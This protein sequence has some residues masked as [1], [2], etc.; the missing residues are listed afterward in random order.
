MSTRIII[1]DDHEIFR[2]GFKILLK[3]Q[4][5]VE[6]IAEAENGQEL[7]QLVNEHQPDLVI[8]DIQ[9]PIM[10]GVEA[11]RVLKQ[12]HPDLG[13]IALSMFNDEDSVVN[14][15]E[16][17]AKGYLLKNTNKQEL[18]EAVETVYNGNVYYC[19]ATS[20]RLTKLIAESKFNP[21]KESSKTVFSEREIKIMQLMCEQ[22]S[23]KEIA[24]ALFLSVRTI[25]GY[26]EKIHEKTNSKNMIG[27]AIYAIKHDYYKIK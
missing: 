6:L 21:Y 9:M 13:I 19:K 15:L 10:N 14:M 3:N 24:D 12:Q 11:T 22:L 7:V 16:A 17:G 8:T 5:V 18:L 2:N 20:E 26:R 27:V 23:N 25:E 1:A 4:D